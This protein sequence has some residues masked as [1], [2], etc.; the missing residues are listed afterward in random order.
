MD[1]KG[2]IVGDSIGGR[3]SV[4]EDEGYRMAFW[5]TWEV[6]RLRQLVINETTLSSTV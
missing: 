1:E 3:F 2:V 5:K 6:V 4:G